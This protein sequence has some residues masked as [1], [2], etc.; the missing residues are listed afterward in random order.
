MTGWLRETPMK[1][2]W[3]HGNARQQWQT[4]EL[5]PARQHS[6]SSNTYIKL[7]EQHQQQQIYQQY[8]RITPNK[9]IKPPNA[10]NTRNMLAE[11]LQQQEYYLAGRKGTLKRNHKQEELY[12]PQVKGVVLADVDCGH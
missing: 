8:F 11:K 12:A 7:N 6:L 3:S 9:E 1:R 10:T 2:E 5:Q 4:Q